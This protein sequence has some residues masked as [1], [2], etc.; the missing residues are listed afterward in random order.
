[1][2]VSKLKV[3]E[4]IKTSLINSNINKL[5]NIQEYVIE[6]ACKGDDI[7]A[8]SKT[9][10]G[11]T[12]AFLIP[13]INNIDI[14]N[15]NV[16]V[17]IITPTRELALQIVKVARDL[18]KDVEGYKIAP[19]VGGSNMDRQIHSLKNGAKIVV[20]TPGRL[21]DHVRRKTLKL[22]H[23]KSAIIDECDEL[24]SMGF[25]QDIKIIIDKFSTSP[26]CML[27]SATMNESVFKLSKEFLSDPKSHKVEDDTADSIKE[28]YLNTF[29]KDKKEVLHDL[30][31][32]HEGKK[33]LVFCNTKKMTDM[34]C[35]F[36]DN[37]K[38]SS[39]S[40]HGDMRQ[41]DR[42]KSINSI[43]N[44]RSN[45]LIATDVAARGTHIDNLEIVINFDLPKLEIQ[46]THR[47]GRVG[48]ANN[49]GI[50]YTIINKREQ[51]KA[52][53]DF[54][55]TRNIK[56]E[57]IKVDNDNNNFIRSKEKLDE[58]NYTKRDS[59]KRTKRSRNS[60]KFDNN[61]KRQYK[62]KTR[63]YKD[64]KDSYSIEKLKT[65]NTKD[66]KYKS[67]DSKNKEN[68]DSQYKDFKRKKEIFKKYNSDN[69]RKSYKS[70]SKN[71][72]NFKNKKSKDTDSNFN[73]KKSTQKKRK[74]NSKF[75]KGRTDNSSNKVYDKKF[76]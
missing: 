61:K 39:T 46:Y 33:I 71:T 30:I 63:E 20:G 32:K 60:N 48:R 21:N 43:K 14:D 12:L 42:E 54:E 36:L 72:S 18:C 53:L 38:I 24:L 34:I 76:K 5:T 67:M 8:Q 15:K 37:K 13:S 52:L 44:G 17:L 55:K 40:L 47:I 45:I 41:R 58:K 66:S 27:F 4:F 73:F 56:I 74:N 10:S 65:D 49:E 29:K 59:E 50:S 9:G 31:K 11:K 57:E 22:H 70:D 69:K 75:S 51:K 64:K 25:Y 7:I 23:L 1:M 16:Q 3:N 35:D 28:Y 68:K 62:D 2:E 6:D 26:Q 19:I